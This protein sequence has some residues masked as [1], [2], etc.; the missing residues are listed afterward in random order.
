MRITRTL[1]FAGA[2]ILSALVGGTLIGSA[3]A[4]EDTDDAETSGRGEYCEVFMD[5]LAAELSVDRDGLVAAGRSAANTALDAAVAAGDLDAEHADALRA[6]IAESD[7]TG[8]AWIGKGFAA[9]FDRGL[10]RG[11]DRGAAKGFLGGNVFEAAADA[12][13]IKSSEL[14]GQLRDAGSLEALS[15][16]LSAT[17]ADVAASVLAA[18]QADLDAAVAEGMDEKHADTIIERLTNWLDGGGE[19][20]GFGRGHGFPGRGHGPWGD[21]GGDDPESEESGS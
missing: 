13:D 4:T 12:L 20:G 11:F 9:G 1:G 18:V 16:E 8:C 15:E 21:R 19:L 3:F 6:R 2:L 14:I 10:D 7:G 5:A 17:Y